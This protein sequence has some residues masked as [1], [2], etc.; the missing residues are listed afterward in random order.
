MNQTSPA[1]VEL[2]PLERQVFA[3]LAAIG[4]IAAAAGMV[5]S[6]DRAWASWLLVSYY[7]LGLGLAGLCFVAIHYTAGAT[8]S[9]AI[10]RVPEALAGT[11]PFSLALLAILFIVHPQL[12]GWTAESFGAGSERALAFKRFWLSRPFF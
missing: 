6:P 3:G 2:S 8:W 7:A 10:R 5:M 12:Y 11:L 1:R 4:A 9:V